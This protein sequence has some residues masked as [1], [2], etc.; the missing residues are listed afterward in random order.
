MALER[1][2]HILSLQ[3]TGFIEFARETPRGGEIDKDSP[4]L[5]QFG[6]QAFGRERLPVT[7]YLRIYGSNFC[8]LKF[9]ADEINTAPDHEQQH[10]HEHDD[11]LHSWRCWQNERAFHPA[12]DTNHKQ[13]TARPDRSFQAALRA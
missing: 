6:L 8:G 4:T 1:L 5:L 3:H 7:S 2:S 13:E 11:S 10:E 9:V 12:R